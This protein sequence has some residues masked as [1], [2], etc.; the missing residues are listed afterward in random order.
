MQLNYHGSGAERGSGDTAGIKAENFA[1]E[2]FQ[3][4]LDRYEGHPH[5]HPR[6]TGASKRFRRN[7]AEGTRVWEAPPSHTTRP[8]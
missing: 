6:A 2:S 5:R 7:P 1:L 3:C 8:H 4:G